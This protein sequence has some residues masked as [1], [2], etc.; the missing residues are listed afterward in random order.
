[1][2][3]VPV[4]LLVLDM[5]PITIYDFMRCVVDFSCNFDSSLFFVESKQSADKPMRGYTEDKAE[6]D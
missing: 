1:M 2:S 5:Q 3:L 6:P 4:L